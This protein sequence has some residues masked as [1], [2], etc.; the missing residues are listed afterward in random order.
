MKDS[1]KNRLNTAMSI[2]NMKQVDLVEKTGLG[3]SAISQYCSG[4]YEPKQRALYKLAKALDVSEAWLMGYDVGMERV[5][6]KYPDNLLKIEKRKIPLLG[7]IAAGVPIV[8]EEHFEYY[9]E[10]GTNINADFCLRVKGDSMINARINDGDIVFIH[11]QSDVDD[12]EIAAV[13]INDEATLKRV[14]KKNNE[15]ILIAENPAYSPIIYKGYEVNEVR[16][17]GKAVAFQSEVV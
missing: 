15:V 8:A 1:F 16:I 17:L 9:V 13:L 4:V 12:G 3:K 14:Y 10:A 7:E 2:R 11:Q 5:I 6:R